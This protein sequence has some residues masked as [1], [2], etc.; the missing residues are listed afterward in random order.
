MTDLENIQNLGGTFDPFA[1]AEKEEAG[2]RSRNTKRNGVIELR[3]E[4]VCRV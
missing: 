3:T 1:D 2:K 4:N